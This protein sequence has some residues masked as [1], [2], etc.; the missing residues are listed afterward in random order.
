MNATYFTFFKMNLFSS[1]Y[2]VLPVFWKNLFNPEKHKG[3][4]KNHPN[5]IT[6]NSHLK[7]F[8]SRT[9]SLLGM[10]MIHVFY[11]ALQILHLLFQT[12]SHW[13]IFYVIKYY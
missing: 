7:Y 11:I 5:F 9:F 10:R 8:E 2:N 1:D 3:E 13:S 4:N 12:V 6:R